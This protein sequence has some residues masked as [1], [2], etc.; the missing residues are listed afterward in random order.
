MH[1]PHISTTDRH[2]PSRVLN[3]KTIKH[4]TVFFFRIPPDSNVAA[5]AVV[6]ATGFIYR[7]FAMGALI[8]H[9][10]VL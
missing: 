8:W 7:S 10:A 4:F 3:G 6:I 5:V 1:L 9:R 2:I